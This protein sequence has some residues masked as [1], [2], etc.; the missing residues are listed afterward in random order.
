[1]SEITKSKNNLVIIDA[2]SIVYIVGSNLENMLLEPLGIIKLDEFLKDILIATKAKEYL[3]FYGGRGSNFR[4]AIAV[5]KPY[6]GNRPTEKPDWYIFWEPIFKKHMKQAW[7]FQNCDNIEADD[8]VAIAAEV[9][10]NNYTKVIIASPDK[11]LYQIPEVWFYNYDKR[12]TVHINESTAT[13]SL[14][15]SYITGDTTDN[16][17]GLVGAGKAVAHDVILDIQKKGLNRKDALEEIKA[18]YIK[19]HTEILRDKHMKKQEAEYLTKYKVDNKLARLNATLKS[20]A[21]KSFVFD[22]SILLDKVGALKLFIEQG[23]LLTLLSTETEGKLHKFIL[24]SPIEDKRID[25]DAIDMFEIELDE[26]SEDEGFDFID[27]L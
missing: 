2:D 5:S 21:L 1:M 16:I 9:H 15:K 6:K 26:L 24:E 27:E 22:S 7:G 14:C 10:R 17:P 25:W 19:W 11:D 18:F 20:T 12:F 3:G 4:K 23:K 13:A 8:A